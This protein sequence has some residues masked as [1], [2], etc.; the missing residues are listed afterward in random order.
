MNRFLALVSLVLFASTAVAADPVVDEQLVR[1][2]SAEMVEAAKEGDTS[3]ISKYYYPGSKILMDMDPASGGDS[4]EVP[5]EEFMMLAEMG[6]AMMSDA[7]MAIEITN[8][9]V[10]EGRNEA[11]IEEHSTIVAEMMGIMIA[12]VSVTETRYGV[13]DGEVKVL[14]TE[15]RLVSI[16]AVQ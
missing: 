3:I 8:V 5:Y 7:E 2:I 4:T 9:S 16:D 12:E 1:A 10:D 13:V 11:T 15:N 6:M 14:E